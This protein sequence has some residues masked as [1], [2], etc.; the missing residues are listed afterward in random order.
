MKDINE[1]T[2]MGRCGNDPEARPVGQ[3]ARVA[4]FSLYTNRSWKKGNGEFD[5]KSEAHR[6]VAWN[7]PEGRGAQLADQVMDKLRKG[8]RVWV[9]GR[10][11]YRSYED[12]R[13][14]VNGE[15][16]K[17]YVTEIVA[18]DVNFIDYRKEQGEE[19]EDTQ[20]GE[21]RAPAQNNRAAKA[22]AGARKETDEFP[23]SLADD[24]DLPF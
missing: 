12:N 6:V 15:P 23:G 17:R 22:P 8:D 24:D 11:E 18:T 21:Q 14:L 2:L 19:G 16:L 10:V 3:H 9:R 7:K 13:T 5:E 1:I 4:Q 20:R